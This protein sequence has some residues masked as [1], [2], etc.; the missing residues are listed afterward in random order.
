[1]PYAIKSSGNGGDWGE[2]G[3]GHPDG[4]DGILLPDGLSGSDMVI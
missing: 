4:E 3:V 1:M 2:E